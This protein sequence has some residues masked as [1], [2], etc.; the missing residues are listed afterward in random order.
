M[1]LNFHR[2]TGKS[3]VFVANPTEYSL[4]ARVAPR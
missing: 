2:A 1:V 4:L 3:R